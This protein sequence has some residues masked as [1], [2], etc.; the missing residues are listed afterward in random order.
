[1]PQTRTFSGTRSLGT[2]PPVLRGFDAAG[3]HATECEYAD[4]VR[5]QYPAPAP[6][7]ETGAKRFCE[8]VQ[9][10]LGEV[11]RHWAL[12]KR[13]TAAAQPVEELSEMPSD[14]VHL[15]GA[16]SRYVEELPVDDCAIP[17]DEDL[18]VSIIDARG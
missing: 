9:Y 1:M 6:D 18:F 16:D 2:K 11:F 17:I 13:G 15:T 7:E 4:S 10:P 3:L 12:S 8:P 14:L 5:D